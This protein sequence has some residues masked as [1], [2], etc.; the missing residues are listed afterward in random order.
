MQGRVADGLALA[1][2]G[3][4]TSNR[5][6]QQL[7]HSQLAAMLA[8]AYLAAGRPAEA[9][10]ILNEAIARFERHCDLLC[11]PDLATL[12]GD[13][14]QALGASA[15]VVEAAYRQ[16]LGLALKWG[17]KTSELR[18]A[19]ALARLY[20]GQGRQ[21]EGYQRL[22]PLL[23]GFQEGFNTVDLI[24]VRELLAQLAP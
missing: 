18:A 23:A 10:E 2:Q 3:M 7:H 6:G 9:I 5:Y 1:R 8:E 21:L 22:A 16:A 19:K 17:A 15:D 24:E 20:Q 12:K 4:E 13:A 14:L 11:L